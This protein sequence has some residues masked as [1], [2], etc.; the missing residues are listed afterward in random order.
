VQ[1]V[2]SNS[3]Y[4]YICSFTK[5]LLKDITLYPEFKNMGDI[6]KVK[7]LD[8]VRFVGGGFSA[9]GNASSFHSTAVRDMRQFIYRKVEPFFQEIARILGGNWYWHE[10][11]DRLQI[12]PAGAVGSSESWHRDNMPGALSE[13]ISFGGWFCFDKRGGAQHF[14]CAQGT[15]FLGNANGKGF[16]KVD[17]K[18]I[19]DLEIRKHKYTVPVGSIIIFDSTIYHQ[20]CPKKFKKVQLRLFTGFRMSKSPDLVPF[21]VDYVKQNVFSELSVPLIKSAQSPPMYPNM[22]F[23]IFRKKLKVFSASFIEECISKKTGYVKKHMPSLKDLGYEIIYKK[24]S[25]DEI[26][27]Y[28]PQSLK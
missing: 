7:D 1:Q 24:Y 13:D 21:C 11:L 25:I 20:V 22:W 18:N 14:I 17:R 3:F 2:I 6:T 16:E 19:K 27:M 23:S 8:N 28:T 5:Q 15:H 4:V 26:N 12:K 9:L 10:L